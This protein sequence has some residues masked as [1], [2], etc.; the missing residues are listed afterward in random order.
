MSR[1]RKQYNQFRKAFCKWVRIKLEQS[2][3]PT[4]FY[5]VSSGVWIG[6][7]K[8]ST[9]GDTYYAEDSKSDYNKYFRYFLKV[10]GLKEIKDKK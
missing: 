8:K 1:T 9:I 6:D 4:H 5:L 2:F 7:L 3:K 10:R